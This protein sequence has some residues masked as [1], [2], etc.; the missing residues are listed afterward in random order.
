MKKLRK[1]VVAACALSMLLV[2]FAG[3]QG[4]GTT[5]A[6]N[7]TAAKES[8]TAG[9]TAAAKEETTAAPQNVTLRFSWWGGDARHQATLEAINLYMERILT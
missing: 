2:L 4:K 6:S 5:G 1:I 9:T 8:T 3:C 7:S